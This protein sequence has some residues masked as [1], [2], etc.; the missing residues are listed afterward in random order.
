[1]TEA[2]G[3]DP[4]CWL[5]RVCEECGRLMEDDV[6]HHC[7]VLPRRGQGGEAGGG[8]DSDRQGA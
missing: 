2:L 4:A 3:G 1:M 5:D 6:A 8:S 7:P